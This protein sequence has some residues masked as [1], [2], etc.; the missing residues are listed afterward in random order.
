MKA[1]D[2]SPCAPGI[3]AAFAGAESRGRSTFIVDGHGELTFRETCLRIRKLAGLF[4]RWGLKQGDRVVLASSEDRATSVIFL[5]LM[6]CGLAPVLLDPGTGP[7]RAR[8]LIEVSRPAAFLVDENLM[9]S[10][11]LG[12]G[13]RLLPIRS[14]RLPGL[15][16]RLLGSAQED[17]NSYPGCLS[18][19][20]PATVP[21]AVGTELDA[22]VLFT[23]GTTSDPK[24]VRISQAA[25]F[26]HLTTLGRVYGY[27]P[28]S[29]IFNSLILSHADG[30]VQGPV[31]AFA[32]GITIVRTVPFQLQTLP[33]LLD[34]LYRWR[35]S[36]LIAVPTILALV[37]RYCADRKDAF[38]TDDLRMVISC[39]AQLEA[40]LWEQFETRFNIPVVNVYGLT[41][42]VIG[43]L[44]AG[45]DADSRRYGTIGRPEDCEVRVVGAQ[46]EVVGEGQHGELQMR[47]PM[48]M[49]GYLNAPEATEQVLIGDGW[50]R[51]G[52]LTTRDPDGCYRILGRIKAL[53][54]RGG[55]NIH[56]EEVT[57]VLQRRPEVVEAVTFGIPDPVWG[58][59]VVSAVA[60]EPAANLREAELI[61]HCR[62]HMEEQ[63]VPSHI[64][65]L[66]SLPRGRSQKVLLEEVRKLAMTFIE[67]QEPFGSLRSEGANDIPNGVL[68]EA[69]TSFRI[70]REELY[71]EMTPATCPGWDSLA[72]LAF[73]TG[74][75][76]RFAIQL[77][78]SE[79]LAIDSLQKAVLT[80]EGW[81][82]SV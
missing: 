35:I 10:W 71:L 68:T 24:G 54:I 31:I 50:F 14:E 39:G 36:H 73:V 78:P 40:E 47:G 8:R 5:A 45:P 26:A 13:E 55:Y 74:L 42:T 49:T 30:M 37:L 32:H 27:G 25:L 75:E 61:A 11:S 22:Y 82:G 62:C 67:S 1:S 76:R 81:C 46:G 52:D 63:K 17:P 72:H 56:P 12:A 44:F 16:S 41:E 79:I 66:P 3:V 18:F 29:R 69:A 65:I 28:G 23:S 51:T 33:D 80:V 34:A 60:V 7:V 77:R 9:V 58:E 70:A 21:D 4:E 20:E 43:G 57:E 59:Q 64:V 38:H 6:R 19:L 48:V 2:K 53:I 15:F